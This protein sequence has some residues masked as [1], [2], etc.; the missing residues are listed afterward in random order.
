M[1]KK[2]DL[3]DMIEARIYRAFEVIHNRPNPIHK[4]R[5][6]CSNPEIVRILED[7]LD[8]NTDG[9][10][11]KLITRTRYSA[12]DEDLADEAIGW[13]HRAARRYRQSRRPVI[14]GIIMLR[15]V[16]LYNPSYGFRSINRDLRKKN[17]KISHMTVKRWYDLAL[18]DI[19][20]YIRKDFE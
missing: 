5:M 18:E 19:Y 17:V 13:L 20:H 6:K 10:R 2:N 16:N 11:S 12:A 8:Y 4:M 9:A 1:D 7:W 15:I 14:H 3:L